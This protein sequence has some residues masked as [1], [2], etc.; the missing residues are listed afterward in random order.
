MTFDELNLIPPILR[1]LHEEGY[2]TPT[3]IQQQAIPHVLDGRDL[4][5]VA[6]T[7]T[8]KTAAFTVPILQILTQTAKLQNQSHSRIRCMVLTP[9]RELAI[10]IGES[11]AA[12]GRHLPLRHTV[13]FGGVGQLPQTNAL[14]RGVEVLIATPGRLLDL[15]NQGFVDLRHIE[16]FVLDEAD[17]M[18]DMGFIND[19]KRILPKLPT[20]RQ[21]LFFSATMPG[22]IQELAGSILKPNPVKVAVTPVS[23][24]ADT[25]T[26]SVYMVQK[27]DKPEL[28]EFILKDKSIKRVLVFTRTKH[29]ADK[30]V[31]TLA[32]ANIPAEAI[33]GNKSQ[34]HRQR[35]LSNFKAGSTR[36]LV[37]TDIAARG[38]DVDELTH[39][40]NYEIPNE[41]E[42]YVHRI[43][44]T[45][46]AGADGVAL[47][48]CDE[49]E[50]AYLQDIQKL[51]RRQ[52]PVVSDHPYFSVFVVP[53]PLT[54]GPAIQRPKGPAG[55]GPRPGRGGEARPPRTGGAGQGSSRTAGSSPGRPEARPA[56]AGSGGGR[57]TSANANRPAGGRPSAGGTGG[58]RRRSRGGN[59]GG[60]QR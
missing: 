48:F 29:G 28:L 38:I 44:R 27:N 32:K 8:G 49:E 1:A 52:I 2:T 24:T 16:V 4:L 59:G 15:M 26:Q 21:T 30:V 10:Q 31:K 13:I 14:K 18:L 6:Q 51:I 50:R 22:A 60:G 55:R 41:P 33:H 47:S 7:G 58:Q 9:T 42:T 37:A 40:I 12:Y 53:V 20:S 39:V 11:F 25:I 36:V 5:G 35:A 3:P 43:G 19:I 23:S 56:A 34:N 45:G 17:R 54:G 46:R 57:S